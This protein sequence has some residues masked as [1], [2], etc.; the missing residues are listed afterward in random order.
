[1]NYFRRLIQSLAQIPDSPERT[2]LSFALGVFWSFSPYL[3]LHTVLAIG[4]AFLFRLNKLA[5]L[6]GVWTNLPWLV[7]PFYA[8]ATW[9]G[10]KLL[11]MEGITLPSI[12]LSELFQAE[13][14]KWLASQWRLLIP[15]FVGSTIISVILGLIAYPVA[16]LIIR[17]YRSI[18]KKE[19]LL[20]TSD[21]GL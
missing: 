8:F 16:L 10:I 13:F 20:E 7:V 12:G 15:A 18:Y 17:R 5:T 19:P 6:L 4:T 1:L 11:G 9:F 3:G 14:W 21:E 2:A